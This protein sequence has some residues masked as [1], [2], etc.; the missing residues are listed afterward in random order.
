LLG[1]PEYCRKGWTI[2]EK[3]TTAKSRTAE[4][5]KIKVLQPQWHVYWQNQVSVAVWQSFYASETWR[6]SVD[7]LSS[8]QRYINAY[9]SSIFAFKLLLLKIRDTFWNISSFHLLLQQRMMHIFSVKFEYM[10]VNNKKERKKF[11]LSFNWCMMGVD[12]AFFILFKYYTHIFLYARSNVVKLV[13][14]MYYPIYT[15]NL[16]L[17]FLTHLVLWAR[18]NSL[19]VHFIYINAQKNY[20]ITCSISN[21]IS[22]TVGWLR[23]DWEERLRIHL[24]YFHT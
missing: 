24:S 2:N 1:F 18:D 4:R 22:Q 16:S 12:Q 19:S 8:A 13:R 10:L 20:I 15:F 7:G 21:V 23:C 5:R 14:I 9:K 6:D 11:V 3:N 17:R